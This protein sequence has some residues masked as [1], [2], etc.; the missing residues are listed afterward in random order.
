MMLLQA[1]LHRRAVVQVPCR[2]PLS[3]AV[4]KAP[5]SDSASPCQYL[6][7]IARL[8]CL[9]NGSVLCY[10][11]LAPAHS[12]VLTR[13]R[14]E[15]CDCVS[16]APLV[17]SEALKC[18]AGEQDAFQGGAHDSRLLTPQPFAPS[19][20]V[21]L[22]AGSPCRPFEVALESS[23]LFFVPPRHLVVA[24]LCGSSHP[25]TARHTSEQQLQGPRRHRQ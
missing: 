20:C 4:C 6:V 11:R 7:G 8:L 21:F 16:S 24:D 22:C 13:V 18:Q 10:P 12:S 15:A 9:C 2:V 5:A 14:S 23:H 3:A 17:D 1:T 25:G 19:H